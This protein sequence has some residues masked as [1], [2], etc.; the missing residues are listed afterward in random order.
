[1]SWGMWYLLVLPCRGKRTQLHMGS[2]EDGGVRA[3]YRLSREGGGVSKR[4]NS[5]HL[6]LT[7]LVNLNVLGSLWIITG[8][9][10]GASC[11]SIWASFV[12]DT[13]GKLCNLAS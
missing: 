4:V 12:S 6:P 13:Q 3:W 9:Y 11:L 1:M 5:I 8:S 10:S 2:A 7:S